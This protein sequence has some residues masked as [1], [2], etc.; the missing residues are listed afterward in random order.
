M[1]TR[2]QILTSRVV[3]VLEHFCRNHR[4]L[5]PAGGNQGG[6]RPVAAAEP[7]VVSAAVVDP[8][9]AAAAE[10]PVVAAAVNA[11]SLL[12]AKELWMES[13]QRP[14]PFSTFPVDPTL[15]AINTSADSGVFMYLAAE[16]HY[17]DVRLAFIADD[18]CKIRYQIAYAVL[19]DELLIEDV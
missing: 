17:F 6:A 13:L 1:S 9:I 8:P 2:K 16:F 10:L 3:S 5:S 15:N 4:L 12:F 19:N 18:I 7:P 11:S 14:E